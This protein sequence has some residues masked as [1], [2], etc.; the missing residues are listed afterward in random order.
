MATLLLIEDEDSI[1]ES[2]RDRLVSE[3]HRVI[4]AANGRV[5]IS[6]YRQ[7]HPQIVITD[8]LMPE[9]DG[10]EV[11]MDIRKERPDQP[12]IAMSA[13]KNAGMDLDVLNIAKKLGATH[14]LVKP[15][16]HADLSAAIAACLEQPH[17]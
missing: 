15:F 9:K 4:E 7:H 17:A 8:I 14:S 2:L 6:L 1:R 3:G 12:I 11:I 16:A 13:E 10:L 5:G